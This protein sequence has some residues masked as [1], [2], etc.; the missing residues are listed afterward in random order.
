MAGSLL[1]APAAEAEPPTR[2]M[3]AETYIGPPLYDFD[4]ENVTRVGTERP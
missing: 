1:A 2:Q 4:I 3:T